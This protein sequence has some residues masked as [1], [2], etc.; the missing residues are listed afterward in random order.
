MVRGLQTGVGARGRI[1]RVR[2]RGICCYVLPMPR[3]TDN[4]EA[5]AREIC[6]RS[7]ARHRTSGTRRPARLGKPTGSLGWATLND[8]SHD[9][10]APASRCPR[11]LDGVRAMLVK[12]FGTMGEVRWEGLV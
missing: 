5:V 2:V 11:P 4:I 12:S 10:A 7:L 9:Q 6:S 3:S 8:M 1:Y